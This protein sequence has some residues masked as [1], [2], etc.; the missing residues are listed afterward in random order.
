MNLILLCIAGNEGRFQKIKWKKTVLL[1]KEGGYS[2]PESN[3]ESEGKR[4]TVEHMSQMFGECIITRGYL[5]E[6]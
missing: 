1:C 2:L 5:R 6:I 4:H 3:T